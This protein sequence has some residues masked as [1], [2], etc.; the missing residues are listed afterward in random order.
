[1][2]LACFCCFFLSNS[3]IKEKATQDRGAATF[4]VSCVYCRRRQL[5]VQTR[6]SY[7]LTYLTYLIT[8]L[9]TYLLNSMQQ[10]P[11]CEANRF[12]ASQEIPR[13]LWNP[14]VHH[15]IHKWPP[16]VPVLSQI[17]PVH[18][19]TSHFLKIHLNIIS[20]F[21]WVFQVVSFHHVSRPKPCICLSSCPYGLHASPSYS[22]WFNHPNNT[23]LGI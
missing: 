17:D 22:S 14:K 2:A 9:L 6:A 13:I 1:M 11:S 8:Y 21:T 10:S 4:E 5:V 7:L 19:P 12:A 18:A 20:P 16:A 3:P 23:G 15:R